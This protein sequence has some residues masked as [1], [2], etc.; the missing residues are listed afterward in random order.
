MIMQKYFIRLIYLF[1]LMPGIANA[2]G[3][4]H[5]SIIKKY[6]SETSINYDKEVKPKLW[7]LN[8]H[9]DLSLLSWKNEYTYGLETSEDKFNFKPVYGL[10][11]AVGCKY[12]KS[13]R[14]DIEFGYVG[15]YSETETE[16]YT[17][18][19]T[20]KTDF[21]LSTMALTINGYYDFK[22]GVYMGLGAGVAVVKTSLSHSALVDVSKT[23]A[24]PMGAVMLGLTYPL[25]DKLNFD[26]RYR[27][28]V[29]TGS[30]FYNL[31]V[32][33]KIGLIMDNSLSVGL[34][35]TF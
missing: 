7:Y 30:K 18:Y 10:N 1:M 2:A 11:L 5:Y 4:G 27:F 16:Y 29:F 23:N 34:R 31:D 32:Q 19:H 20:E 24:S 6:D 3:G 17:D 26:M 12:G 35:Y 13:W 21:N 28:A 8:A 9:L 15:R 14:G 33:T 25:N 22:T